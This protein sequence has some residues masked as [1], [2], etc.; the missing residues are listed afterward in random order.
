M[1]YGA[2][3]MNGSRRKD[4]H[5]LHHLLHLF[6]LWLFPF[7]V[8][9]SPDGRVVGVRKRRRCV[10]LREIVDRLRQRQLLTH[11]S[12]QSPDNTSHASCL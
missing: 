5:C 10:L 2:G 9:D 4:S 8:W 1:G 7:R 6:E 3:E 11:H 12:R